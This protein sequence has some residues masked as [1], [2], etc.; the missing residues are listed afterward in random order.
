MKRLGW[1]LSPSYDLQSFPCLERGRQ[2]AHEDDVCELSGHVT[3][4]FSG[5]LIDTF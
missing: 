4:F 2:R 3:H 5:A 1:G